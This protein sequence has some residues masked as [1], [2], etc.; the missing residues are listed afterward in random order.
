VRDFQRVEVPRYATSSLDL[1]PYVSFSHDTLS[2]VSRGRAGFDVFWKPDGHNQVSAAVNPDFG[3]VES[4]NLVVNFS[5]IETFFEEKKRPFF[6][7]G[8]QLFDLRLNPV[9][10]DNSTSGP[11]G[12]YAAYRRGTGRRPE[13]SSDCA[14]GRQVHR[15]QGDEEYGLSVLWRGIHC[16][17]GSTVFCRPLAP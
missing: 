17:R 12:E 16:R 15:I 2:G 11:S 1:Y 13:A 5:A 9:Q 4:D 7:Q 14:R 8:Q 6:T 3:Q 10:G